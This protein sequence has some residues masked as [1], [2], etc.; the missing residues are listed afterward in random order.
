MGLLCLNL[1][2]PHPFG[3][4]GASGLGRRAGGGLLLSSGQTPGYRKR[5][6]QSQCRSLPWS[7]PQSDK[8]EWK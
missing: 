3:L 2:Q 8:G 4:K 7:G 6:L 1:I 5:G